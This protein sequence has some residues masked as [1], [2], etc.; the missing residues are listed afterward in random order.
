MAWAG[1][2]AGIV[3]RRLSKSAIWCQKLA[4]FAIPYFLATIILHRWEKI[5]SP[6]AIGLLMLGLVILIM[7]I[8]FA[9]RAFI[10]LW[11]DGAKGGKKTIFGLFL[12]I[13]MLVP[14]L[15]SAIFSQQ[16]PALND[17]STEVEFPPQFGAEAYKLRQTNND[18]PPNDVDFEY[19]EDVKI[20]ITNAY[21]KVSPRRYPAG[22]ERVY[23]AVTQLI[24]SRGWHITQIRGLPKDKEERES[25]EEI[26]TQIETSK[27]KKKAAEE[28]EGLETSQLQDILIDAVHSTL[29][30]AFKV[31]VVIAIIVEEENTLV[32]MRS[33]GR[34]GAH[35][36]GENAR[37]IKDFMN[38]LDQNLI[39][40]AGEG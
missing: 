26:K 39:G 21:P 9:L 28:N 19:D 17:L 34:W 40:I 33:A 25:K 31:D 5:T 18:L 36:F 11:N 29:V 22:P 6:Q 1:E 37:V 38:D 32:Q 14:F 20:A 30:L 12:S 16:Y 8:L 3:E 13:L 24:D 2:M 35:D 27:S 15:V 4:L 7:S 23:Q 10:Q